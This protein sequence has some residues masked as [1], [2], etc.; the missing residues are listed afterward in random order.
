MKP[1]PDALIV[2]GGIIGAACGYFLAR[3]GL[4]VE[5]LEGGIIGGGTTAAGMGH[6]AVM[7]D[8]PAQFALSSLSCRLWDQ[9]ADRLPAT[10]DYTRDGAIWVAETDDE[11][12]I[13]PAKATRYQTR[14]VEVEILNSQQLATMEPQLRPG[15]AGGL[16]LPG[17]RVLYPPVVTTWFLQQVRAMGGQV[18]S[19][20]EVVEI[21]EKGVKT[22]TG[23]RTAGLVVNAAGPRCAEL[24]PELPV[25]PRKGHLVI[26]DRHPG[27]I[28][29][30][31]LELGYLKSAHTPNDESVAF[32]VQPRKTGQVLIGSSRQHVGWDR[33]FDHRL[34]AKMIARATEFL[35]RLGQLTAIRGWFGF[36][37]ATTDNLP[38]IGPW[39]QIANSWV[40]SGHE[41]LGHT[42]AMGTGM[43]LAQ[44]ITG[45]DPA[46]DPAPFLPQRVLS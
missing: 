27:F 35:P 45:E 34:V 10:A 7:D 5:V 21:E 19:G 9:I 42:N 18:I 14:G 37:P 3:R 13:I 22:Q 38:L 32:N 1:A 16:Y 30:Q 15:L 46:L 26:T 6:L 24:M 11:A 20:C 17:D 2:G 31:M 44:L 33:S 40:A 29:H 25:V 28:R 12:A 36:R 43:L 4:R 39:P 8:S 41:G 23:F